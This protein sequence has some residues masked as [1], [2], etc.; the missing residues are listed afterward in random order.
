MFIISLDF[1]IVSCHEFRVYMGSAQSAFVNIL[2]WIPSCIVLFLIAT[3]VG[4]FISPDADG[5]GF[6]EMKAVLSGISIE[7]YFTFNT[8]IAKIIG[9]FAFIVSGNSS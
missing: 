5:S 1:V 7:K 3:S 2:I 9:L 6:P 4:Y 8:F